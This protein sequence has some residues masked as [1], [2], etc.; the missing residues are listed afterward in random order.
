MSKSNNPAFWIGTIP[1][2][3]ATPEHGPH[4]DDEKV[5]SDLIPAAVAAKMIGRSTTTLARRARAGYLSQWQH[6][7]FTGYMYV[8]SEVMAYQRRFSKVRTRTIIPDEERPTE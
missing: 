7:D 6:P 5:P 3:N 4:A 8:K 1:V 2:M